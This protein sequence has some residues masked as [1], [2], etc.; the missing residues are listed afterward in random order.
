MELPSSVPTPRAIAIRGRSTVFSC[1]HDL[2]QV[3]GAVHMQTPGHRRVV[4]SGVQD[5]KGVRQS[6]C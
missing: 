4:R 5:R 2:A 1:V 3:L 6:V